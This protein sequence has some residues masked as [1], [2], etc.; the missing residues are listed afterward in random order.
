[1]GRTLVV[2]LALTVAF[3]P[4]HGQSVR[5]PIIRPDSAIQPP[6][7]VKARDL[8]AVVKK[9]AAIDDMKAALR[10]LV[11]LEE[12]YWNDH[13]TYTTDGSALGIY[14]YKNGQPLVQ[15]IFAG[16]RGWTG[17]ATERTWKGNGCVVYVGYEKELPGGVPK[18]MGAG[19]VA[20]S[21][22]SP[23]CDEP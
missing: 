5:P 15:V 6:I 14:P 1:M 19:I 3:T 10:S 7:D 12:K 13:G 2:A 18:T 21:E 11:A 4:A 23:T 20:K 9:S 17:M 8:G 22:G 16:S